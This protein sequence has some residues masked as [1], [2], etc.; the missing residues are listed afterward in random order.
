MSSKFAL[1]ILTGGAIIKINL[2]N[3][4]LFFDYKSKNL[5]KAQYIG[6]NFFYKFVQKCLTRYFRGD[7]LSTTKQTNERE[8][9]RNVFIGY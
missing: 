9:M 5:H 8:V 6:K 4:K 3:L 1:H 7:I 2:I